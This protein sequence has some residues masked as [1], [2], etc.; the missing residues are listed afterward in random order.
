MSGYVWGGTAFLLTIDIQAWGL[1][2]P[3]SESSVTAYFKK[4]AD[5][6]DVMESSELHLETT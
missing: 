6:P 4:D 1:E 2:Q 3:F 5:A